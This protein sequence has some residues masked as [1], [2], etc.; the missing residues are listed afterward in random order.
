MKIIDSMS[1]AA[2]NQI[3]AKIVKIMKL[4]TNDAIKGNIC[5]NN[6]MRLYETIRNAS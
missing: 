2:S 6:L 5:A 1:I 3:P 4:K